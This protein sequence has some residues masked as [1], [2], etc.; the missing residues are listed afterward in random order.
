MYAAQLEVY[1]AAQ[2]ESA[3]GREIEALALTNAALKLR[4]CQVDWDFEDSDGKRSNALKINQRIWSILQSELAREDN[5]LP[6]QLKKDLLNL[7]LL[8]DKR[9]FDVMAFPSPE[10]LDM[11][12]RINL[13]IAAGLRGNPVE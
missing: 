6:S 2:K 9:T 8:V 4:K 13:N 12:I 1:K 3:S 7:S 10:K 5:P 11:L